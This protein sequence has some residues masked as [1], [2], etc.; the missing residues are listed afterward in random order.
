M[1]TINEL[2][3]ISRE[4]YPFARPD[5]VP[6]EADDAVFLPGIGKSGVQYYFLVDFGSN[7]VTCW[8]V[9]VKRVQE[10][11]IER[12]DR[13]SISAVPWN[14][15]TLEKFVDVV[16]FAHSADYHDGWV[17]VSF[18]EGNFILALD[19]SSD[20]YEVIFDEDAGLSKIYSS[21]NQIHNGRIY[22]TRWDITETFV[23]ESDRTRPVALE[24]G[25]YDIAS[26]R[27]EVIDVIP[28]PD[29]I[30]YT[31]VS[32]DEQNL[33]IVEMTQDP[34]V[35]PPRDYEFDKLSP[36]DKRKLLEGGLHPS[37][38]I[39]YNLPSRKVHRLQVSRGPAHIE[40]DPADDAVYHLS[41]HNLSTNND[42][43]YCFGN[44]MIEQYRIVDGESVR[45]SA[46][47]APDLIRAPSHK[48]FNYKGTPLMVLPVTPN[49]IHIVD[50]DKLSIYKKINLSKRAAALPSLD[51]GP[52][53]Y[54]RSTEDKT[55]YTIH[56]INETPYLY[57]SSIW[58]V[59]IFDFE[60]ESKLGSVTYNRDKPVALMG[61]ASMFELR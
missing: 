5:S 3:S 24:I 15:D 34:V 56:P 55:P 42:T 16:Y 51:G 47:E 4:V 32:K 54:S 11:L 44:S 53:A 18:I 29:D 20:A 12:L 59:T 52:F 35:K 40:W 27:F 7:T 50:M 48:L 33:V 60:S 58:N 26:K 10:H 61:H 41:S 13:S 30:H 39:T 46:Y 38:V 17:Y 6:A 37:E 23:H 57:L 36:E 9:D 25:T 21:T 19:T 8:T 31:A 2:L 49:A 43:L 22:F 28:G 45:Q 1:P 14:Q